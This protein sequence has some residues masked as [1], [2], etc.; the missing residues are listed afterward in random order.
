M[1]SPSLCISRRVRNPAAGAA[2]AALLAVALGGCV[3]STPSPR[4]AAKQ[5]AATPDLS[6]LAGRNVVAEWQRQL[7]AFLA[8]NGSVDPAL[9]AQLPALR[10]PAVRRPGQIVF[11]ATDIESFVAERDGFDAFGLLVGKLDTGANLGYV[12]IV[13]SVARSEYRAI[14]VADV[15]AVALTLRD[16]N[17][18][19]EVG[20]S[21]PRALALYRQ[22]TDRTTAVRFPADRDRFRMVAC[23]PDVC[24]EELRSGARWTLSMGAGAATRAPTAVQA[25]GPR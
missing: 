25:V 21:D 17:V 14:A 24:V 7:E 15:R 1:P 13:G 12:F 11:A 6:E 22:D 3:T 19:W 23:A 2:L 16:G 20:P 8:S 10:S 18:A 5:A 9:L 4:A